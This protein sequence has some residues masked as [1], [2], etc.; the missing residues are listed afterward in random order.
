M[1]FMVISSTTNQKIRVLIISSVPIKRHYFFP[2]VSSAKV[3]IISMRRGLPDLSGRGMRILSCFLV[4]KEY[5]L[6]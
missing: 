2:L 5:I 3:S 1:N 6:S 4:D